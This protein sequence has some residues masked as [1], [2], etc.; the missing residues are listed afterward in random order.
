MNVVMKSLTAVAQIAALGL[1]C[2][3]AY[4][5]GVGKTLPAHHPGW[6]SCD[7]RLSRAL[8]YSAL[9][10]QSRD[11]LSGLASQVTEA[12]TIDEIDTL[13]VEGSNINAPRTLWFE[14]VSE[15]GKCEAQVFLKSPNQ[16]GNDTAYIGFDVAGFAHPKRGVIETLQG[17]EV[18]ESIQLDTIGVKWFKE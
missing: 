7:G 11:D 1:L 5:T 17:G 10:K 2:L 3:I 9:L 6:M 16:D 18:L 12:R 8:F 14:S 4:N 15:P 13:V